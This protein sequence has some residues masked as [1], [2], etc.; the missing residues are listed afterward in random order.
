VE[1][2]GMG[3]DAGKEPLMGGLQQ[4]KDMEILSKVLG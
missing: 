2:A 1:K 4:K 3:E